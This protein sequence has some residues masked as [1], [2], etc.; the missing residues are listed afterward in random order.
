MNN[1]TPDS[2]D[3][4]KE[5]KAIGMFPRL[6]LS[7]SL[8]LLNTIYELGEGEPVRR[9]TI[10]DKLGKSPESGPSRA[11]I[12]TSNSGYGLITGSYAAE[13]L[14]V[15]DRGKQIASAS[16]SALKF[17]A[18]YDSLFSNEI[19]SAFV[20][21]FNDRG[22]PLDEIAIEYLKGNH[23]LPQDDAK[24]CWAVFKDNLLEQNL[25]QELS[26]KKVIISQSAA[27][28]MHG[29]PVEKKA[30][31]STQE[32]GTDSN[33]EF[34]TPHKPIINTHRI[35][36]GDSVAPQIHFNIQVVIPENA[37]PETYEI[38]FKSIA[39][40]LLGRNDGNDA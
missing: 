11:L 17:Q 33:H 29:K 25:I 12:T 31:K 22:V 1:L 27:L 14:G 39:T 9:R 37:S 3:K 26:G 23:G 28:E 21:R 7:K 35:S 19:F 24:D 20:A 30:D 40:H 16:N 6:S 34:G 4:K 15:T 10:F 36:G 38:I 2:K 13:Y 18:I 5:K 32:T 8:E